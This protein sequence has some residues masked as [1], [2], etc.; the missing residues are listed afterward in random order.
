MLRKNLTPKKKSPQDLIKKIEKS[1]ILTASSFGL[2]PW[3]FVFVTNQEIKQKIFPVSFNQIQV[4][5]CSH[6][7]ILCR[8]N[9]IDEKRN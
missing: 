6:L 9:I 1:L 8:K 3:K 4:V 2:Q 5:D 7:I